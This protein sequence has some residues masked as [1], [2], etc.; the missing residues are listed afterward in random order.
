[1]MENNMKSE[2]RGGPGRSQGR[3]PKPQAERR[4]T[5]TVRLAPETVDFL[6]SQPESQGVVIDRAVKLLTKINN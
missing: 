3:K 1:M 6:K 2:N 4:V 5:M